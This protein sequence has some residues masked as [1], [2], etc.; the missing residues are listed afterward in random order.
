MYADFVNGEPKK[1]PTKKNVWFPKFDL[2]D[3]RR[4]VNI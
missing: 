2:K 4:P 1:D 3:G